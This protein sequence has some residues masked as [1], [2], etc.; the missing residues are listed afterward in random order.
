MNYYNTKKPASFT[1]YHSF[2][3]VAKNSK[4]WLLSQDVCTSQTSLAQFPRRKTI[5]PGAKFQFQTDLID[6]SAKKVQ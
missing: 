4:N 3:N 5:V 6:F 1:G 2:S